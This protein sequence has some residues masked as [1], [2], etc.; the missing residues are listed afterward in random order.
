MCMAARERSGTHIVVLTFSMS[1]F[2]ANSSVLM[3][4]SDRHSK[5]DLQTGCV[6]VLG[7][8]FIPSEIA[9]LT[10]LVNEFLTNPFKL[11]L[12]STPARQKLR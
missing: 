4:P 12:H 2:T 10:F 3:T 11:A 1:W 8:I 5:S 7:P 6:L 9:M